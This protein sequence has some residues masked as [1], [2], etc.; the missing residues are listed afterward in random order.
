MMRGRPSVLVDAD[1]SQDRTAEAMS[2]L[3]AAFHVLEGRDG[4]RPWDC[5]ALYRSA[6]HPSAS[7]AVRHAI[8]FVLSVWNKHAILSMDET[9][10][11]PGEKLGPFDVVEALA[12]WD[13]LNRSAFLTWAQDPWWP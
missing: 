3:C 1:A 7:S 5:E 6:F 13:A 10:P 11:A 4:T 12:C 8:R 2:T 9:S